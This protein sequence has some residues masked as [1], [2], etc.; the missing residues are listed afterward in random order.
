LR[1]SPPAVFPIIVTL[2]GLIFLVNVVWA[3]SV[4]SARRAS[5]LF[6]SLAGIDGVQ[7]E[8]YES[9]PEMYAAVDAV[10]VGR[11]TSIQMGRVIGD[12]DNDNAAYY[13]TVSLEIEE[14]LRSRS[15]ALP[16]SRV[17]SLELLSF[18]PSVVER[19]IAEFVPERGLYFLTSKGLNAERAGE[20]AAVAAAEMPFYRLSIAEGVIREIGGQAFARPSP[21]RS[22]LS[23]HHGRPFDSV[24]RDVADGT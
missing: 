16:E 19:M 6:W 14:V 2:V 5:D 18:Y 4:S 17:V 8:G 7:S 10:V 24:V 22:V 3:N 23:D 9:A 12:A 20:P 11:I 13:A 21:D 1:R 15:N